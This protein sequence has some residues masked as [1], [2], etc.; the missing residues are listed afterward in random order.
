MRLRSI[1]RGVTGYPNLAPKEKDDRKPG[2]KGGFPEFSD[3]NLAETGN[4]RGGKM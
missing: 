2:V 4:W 3:S 1:G